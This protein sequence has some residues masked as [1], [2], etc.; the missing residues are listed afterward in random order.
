MLYFLRQQNIRIGIYFKLIDIDWNK[1]YPT[2]K[3]HTIHTHIRY[4]MK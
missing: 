3:S 4:L 2:D 1:L